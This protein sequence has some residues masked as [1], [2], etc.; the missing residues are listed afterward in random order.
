M[1]NFDICR[2]YRL[3]Q[4]IFNTI[5]MVSIVIIFGFIEIWIWWFRSVQLFLHLHTSSVSSRVTYTSGLSRTGCRHIQYTGPR[6]T[7]SAQTKLMMERLN[8][9]NRCCMRASTQQSH[10]PARITI[11]VLDPWGQE[12]N[13]SV[14]NSMSAPARQGK[15]FS[16][17]DSE[18]GGK[19]KIRERRKEKPRKCVEFGVGT[20]VFA[21]R[22]WIIS[23]HSSVS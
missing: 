2:T 5:I 15:F 6:L 18:R 23:Y 13:H 1:L 17:E 4:W 16:A 14:L 19:R 22:P 21:S 7:G 8:W 9:L 10:Q 11:R 3:L 12:V 20:V